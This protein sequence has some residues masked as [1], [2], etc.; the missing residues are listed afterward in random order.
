V[1]YEIC[2]EGWVDAGEKTPGGLI[3]G[4]PVLSIK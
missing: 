3:I 4:R 1:F 2:R